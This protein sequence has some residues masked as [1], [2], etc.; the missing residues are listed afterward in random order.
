MT[1]LLS[2][3]AAWLALNLEADSAGRYISISPCPN[4]YRGGWVIGR[5]WLGCVNRRLR[6]VA[7]KGGPLSLPPRR[8]PV[9]R[10]TAGRLTTSRGDSLRAVGSG[11]DAGKR[12]EAEAARPQRQP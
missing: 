11:C 2:Q 5:S 10:A 7:S 8:T 12:A 6:R 4:S 3:R 1:G 9:C